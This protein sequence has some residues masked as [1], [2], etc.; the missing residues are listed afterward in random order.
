VS[1]PLLHRLLTS[2]ECYEFSALLEAKWLA[3]LQ[4]VGQGLTPPRQDCAG[5]SSIEPALS[6]HDTER[7]PP[8]ITPYSVE[9]ESF[10]WD[11]A[12][13]EL[14]AGRFQALCGAVG[15]PK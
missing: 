12:S 8:P 5:Q 15:W 4:D 11:L 2:E 9:L 10:S 1:A 14:D 6:T 7:C 3:R 13:E